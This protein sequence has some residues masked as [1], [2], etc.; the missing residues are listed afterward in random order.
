MTARQRSLGQLIRD[1]RQRRRITVVDLAAKCNV[2]R[3]QVHNWERDTYILPKNLDALARA[4]NLPVA[5]L[6][7]A[8]GKRKNPA[9]RVKAWV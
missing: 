5:S 9:A 2:T 8:N 4:L 6:W 1:T 7:Q 3:G